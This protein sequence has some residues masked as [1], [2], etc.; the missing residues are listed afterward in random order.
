MLVPPLAIKEKELD[1][2]INGTIKTIK[3][4]SKEL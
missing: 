4:V 2:L 1:F 3:N